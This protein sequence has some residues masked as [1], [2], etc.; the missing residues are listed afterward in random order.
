M[1]CTTTGHENGTDRHR[2]LGKQVQLVVGDRLHSLTIG[3]RKK[4][5]GSYRIFRGFRFRELC[6]V[7]YRDPT[8]STPTQP[9]G[10]GDSGRSNN[11]CGMHSAEVKVP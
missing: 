2:Q 9:E 4:R 1:T 6:L 11:W 3:L 7:L 10:A 5:P 8:K